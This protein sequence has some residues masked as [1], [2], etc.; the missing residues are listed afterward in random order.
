MSIWDNKVRQYTIHSKWSWVRTS[1]Y[2]NPVERILCKLQFFGSRVRKWSSKVWVSFWKRYKKRPI[3]LS[4]ERAFELD[5]QNDSAGGCRLYI[6]LYLS[7]IS[8]YRISCPSHSERLRA[9]CLSFLPFFSLG[10]QNL[11]L[12]TGIS[13]YGVATIRLLKIIGL[14]CRI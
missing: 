14:F 11:N 2:L 13:G 7:R 6:I 3:G 9:A 5:F 12:I 8:R 4:F 1:N 10:W